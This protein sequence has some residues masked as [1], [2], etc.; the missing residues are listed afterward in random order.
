MLTTDS[1]GNVYF[2]DTNNAV[3]RE[4]NAA[5]GV[6]NTVVGVA[7]TG[8]NA[9]GAG[10]HTVTGCADGV[11]SKS[12]IT[13][14]LQGIAIDSYGNLYFDDATTNTMSVV[15]RGG[16]QIA[17]FIKLVN[18]T[19][20]TTAGGV[21]PGYVYHVAGTIN[22]TNCQCTATK[23]ASTTA[24]AI[25][26]GDG[27]LAFNSGA[28]FGTIGAISLDSAGNIYV[29]D[30]GVNNTIRVINTQSVAQT[31]FGVTVQPGFIASFA[32]CGALTV[33]CPPGAGN[34]PVTAANT[35]IGGSP[36][37]AVFN[38]LATGQGQW[39]NVDAYGNIYELNY[40]GATPA[41]C[42][43]AAVA[44]AGGTA[45][46]NLINQANKLSAIT[47][48][49]SLTATP[50]D[51][52]YLL[53][54]LTLR[55]GS[56]TQD[57]VGNLYYEDNHYG[58]IYRIDINSV[59]YATNY[60]SN[61]TILEGGN[62]IN[63]NS[64][65][66]TVLTPAYCYGTGS[67]F[68]PSTTTPTLTGQTTNDIYGDGCPAGMA[69]GIG[70]PHASGGFGSATADG[71]GNLYIA[72]K[73][74]DLVQEV[75]L[76]NRFPAT[77]VG[78]S[79]Q[80]T[81]QI[82]FDGSNLPVAIAA[83]QPPILTTSSIVMAPGSTDFSINPIDTIATTATASFIFISGASNNGIITTTALTGNTGLPA[84]GNTTGS[85]DKSVDCVVNVIFTPTAGGVRQ[86]Q[87]VVTTAN[88]SVYNFGLTGI[89]T[90]GQLAIDGGAEMV[91][92]FSGL[93]NTAQVAVGP[94]GNV[95]V[96]DPTNNRIAVMAGMEY[97]DN[98][99]HRSEEPPRRC[100]RCVRQR[101]YLG[102]WE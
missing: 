93:G 90:G 29:G 77:A 44:Y 14:N 53:Q 18:P 22:L 17:N 84:C 88:G 63:R 99:W 97:A 66:A 100:G 70:N 49:P 48:V 15:Y 47:N 23:T 45:L 78:Q 95:Y 11:P 85:V 19:G 8:C 94:T 79:Y 102:H 60:L 26:A 36:E 25:P 7:P 37:G 71:I 46:G 81:I 75:A 52:Y 69:N 92:P 50:G 82:H 27:N 34:T 1:V 4:I 58:Q 33:L 31:Y 32:N 13:G 10:C 21:L 9:S 64:I 91:V 12:P 20:V 65:I 16:T 101:L 54:G 86:S 57:G 51:F 3:I 68:A 30:A 2:L 67:G 55:P 96:A 61:A 43:C 80:Q 59:A 87:L 28:T 74:N 72:N 39:M 24:A 42:P 5:T 62:Q 56:I 76:N 40:K 83:S 73:S 41:I 38:T 89:G 35:G 98:G 6:V